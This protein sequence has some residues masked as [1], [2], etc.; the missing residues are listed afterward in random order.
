MG[1]SSGARRE[2]MSVTLRE[3]SCTEITVRGCPASSPHPE[4]EPSLHTS[5][6]P[7]ASQ[8][9]LRPHTILMFPVHHL[10]LFSAFRAQLLAREGGWRGERPWDG[11]GGVHTTHLQELIQVYDFLR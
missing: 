1:M 2:V 8:P 4:S 10:R 6:P 5:H 7:S 11:A 9:R 3:S